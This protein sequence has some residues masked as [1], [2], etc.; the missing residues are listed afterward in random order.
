MAEGAHSGKYNILLIA[1]DDMRLNLGCY[2]DPIAITPNLDKLA[3]KSIVFES[4]YCQFPSCNASRA[5]ILTGMRPDSIKVW[6]LNDNFRDKNPDVVTLPQYFKQNEYHTESIGK[7]LH[8]Y[9]KI[10]DNEKSWSVPARFD[11]ENHFTD[12]ALPGN[13]RK[14]SVKGSIAERAD[15]QD[16]AYADGRITLD[17]VATI[18]RL[19][20]TDKPFFLAVGFLKPHS[21]FNAPS[22]YWD[23]YSQEDMKALGPETKPQGASPLNW[24]HYREIRTFPEFPDEGNP[25]DQLARRMRHGYYAATSFVD[26]NVGQ[27]LQA[28]DENGLAENTIVVFWSDH[29]YHLGENSHWSKVM[30]RELDGQVPLLLKV[31]GIKNSRSKAIVEYTDLFPTLVELC[32][33]P[34]HEGIDGQSFSH[35][36]KN[37]LLDARNAAL[38]QVCRPW[39]IGDIEQ[40]GYSLRTEQFRFTQWIDFKTGKLLS[41]ELYD[42]SLDPLERINVVTDPRQ[43]SN[44][45][46]LR[47]LMKQNR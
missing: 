41:E 11:Q 12:Y 6:R 10:R 46:Y 5:S 18:K 42:H 24:F 43:E 27:L 39:P 19:A 29:G 30:P 25:S 37:P 20:K 32:G 7:V 36:V 15:V 1:A 33:L 9:N 26:S 28:L 31:P 4:A 38:T 47:Q 3:A 40:M 8:N 17:A 21:P 13:N 23:L 45:L 22:K 44:L 35:L 14:G 2:G 34:A 16:A